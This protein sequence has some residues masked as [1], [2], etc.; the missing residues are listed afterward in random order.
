[1]HFGPLG[2]LGHFGLGGLLGLALAGC[3][4]SS[5]GGSDLSAAPRTASATLRDRAGAELGTATFTA[6]ADGKVDVQVKITHATPGT[7]GLHIH[8]GDK[9]ETSDAGMAEDFT[10]AGG[11]FNPGNKMHGDPAAAEHHAGDFGNLAVMTV[12]ADGQG[13]ISL[14][15]D[16]LSLAEGDVRS[17]VGKAIIFHEKRDDLTTQP[18]G[19]S[20]ARIGC[21]L[22]K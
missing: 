8:A 4:G 15:S 19:D 10:S 2:H 20:G 16:G 1:M 11:H 5:P 7:H 14:V 17:P 3:P 22:I 6:R 9:C 18:S 13:Q 12:G 21:G